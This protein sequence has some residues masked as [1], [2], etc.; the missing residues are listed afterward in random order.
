MKVSV[1]T[2]PIMQRRLAM[3]E[4][5]TAAFE[6]VIQAKNFDDVARLTMDD[7][8][9]LHEVCR[10]SDPPIRYLNESSE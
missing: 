9:E 6:E 4:A 8:D 5:K 7:S 1:E 3:I 10:S 2:S